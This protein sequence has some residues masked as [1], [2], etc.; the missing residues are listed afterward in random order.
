MNSKFKPG[1]KNFLAEKLFSPNSKG[2]SNYVEVSNFPPGFFGNGAGILRE[3]GTFCK[4][5][6]LERQKVGNKTI[7]IRTIGFA[8]DGVDSSIPYHVRKHFKNLKGKDG[9]E[10]PVLGTSMNLEIDHKNGRKDRIGNNI[11]DYQLLSKPANNAK[12]QHC[13]ECK[14]SG[15]RFDAKRLNYSVSYTYGGPEYSNNIGCR[16]CHWY[17]PKDFHERCQS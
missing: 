6:K 1:T 5:Y 4:K 17:D 11:S 13:K 2:V 9:I 14:E 12:R 16:G 15:I 10:C 3:D 7:R 8:D